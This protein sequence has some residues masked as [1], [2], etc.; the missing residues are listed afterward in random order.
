MRILIN[1]GYGYANAGDEAQLAA[2]LELWRRLS[3]GCV[4]DVF[5]PDPVYTSKVH[6]APDLTVHV[7][8]RIVWFDAHRNP[9]YFQSGPA[10]REWFHRV[11][12]ANRIGCDRIKAGQLSADD[13]FP[14]GYLRIHQLLR[15]SDVLFISGGGFLTGSTLSRLWEN[16][17][18]I[19]IAHAYGIPIL[20]SGQ[21]IG[22]LRP[23]DLESYRIV[24]HLALADLIYTRDDISVG[25]AL[26]WGVPNDRLRGGFDDALFSPA[27]P[28]RAV[29]ALLFGNQPAAPYIVVNVQEWGTDPKALDGLL[30]PLA[31]VIRSVALARKYRIVV[32]PMLKQDGLA[33]SRFAELVGGEAQVVHYDYDFRM[34]RAIVAHAS[35][36]VTMK[37]HPIIFAMGEQVPCVA[38][39]ATPYYRAKN[40]G[41]L[42]L[43]GMEPFFIDCAAESWPDTLNQ[44]ITQAFDERMHLIDRLARRLDALRPRSGEIIRR[45]LSSREEK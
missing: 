24:Q 9:A 12:E 31:E 25:E 1:G 5:T 22:L 32:L 19:R 29:D 43:F 30:A 38:L 44:K 7:G 39:S 13:A 37:H 42:A 20:V 45:W 41:A 15:G 6:G 17:L 11:D 21:T 8:P 16:M 34:A 36:C 14:V 2:N 26:E 33:V 4:F 28:G 27:A 10:F 35:L 3:P 23:D 40:E 18:L